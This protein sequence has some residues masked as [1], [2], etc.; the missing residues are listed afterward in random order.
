MNQMKQKRN[1]KIFPSQFDIKKFHVPREYIEKSSF[2]K[3]DKTDNKN[4][5]MGGAQYVLFPKYMYGDVKGNEKADGNMDTLCVLTD[6]IEMNR[7][8]LFTVDNKYR[9][10]DDD[11]NKF[12]LPMEKDNGGDGAEKLCSMF[13]KIDEYYDKEIE[14]NPSKFL[15]I[16]Q[17]QADK[18][19]TFIQNLSYIP[20]V[21]KAEAPPNAVDFKEWMRAKV[22][23]SQKDENGTKTFPVDILDE[24]KEEHTVKTIT[25]LRKYFS[26]GCKARFYLELKTFWALKSGKGKRNEKECGFKI[27]CN[28]IQIIES[29]KFSKKEETTWGDILGDDEEQTSNVAETKPQEKTQEKPQEKPQEKTQEKHQE[30]EDS[31]SDSDSD[32]SDTDEKQK[33]AKKKPEPEPEPEPE[34][35]QKSSKKTGKAK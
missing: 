27:F 28:K 23:I 7:G 26:R 18:T 11:C 14:E 2:K 13:K 33:N 34:T 29:S 31:S 35:K 32:S 8:G 4:T 25:E 22:T 15:A 5:A 21:R 9:F 3:D 24:N 10:S 12:W 6:V 20:L 17:S 1:N 30:K 16:K 19:P